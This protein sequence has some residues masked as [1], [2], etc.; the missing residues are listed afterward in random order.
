MG[1]LDDLGFS[2]P[3]AE[4]ERLARQIEEKGVEGTQLREAA[5]RRI[6][7]LREDLLANFKRR[8]ASIVDRIGQERGFHII[9]HSDSPGLAWASPA[10][11]ITS[12]LVALVNKETV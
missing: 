2:G 11:D 7:G 4:R 1:Q 8:V 6:K 9:L 12:E 3:P 10:V 5:N